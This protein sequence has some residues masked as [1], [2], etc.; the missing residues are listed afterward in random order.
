MSTMTVPHSRN[1]TKPVPSLRLVP[2]LGAK[3]DHLAELRELIRRAQAAEREESAEV[4]AGL[5]AAGLTRLAGDRAVA[6]VGE[7][8]SLTVDPELFLEA[9][10]PAGYAAVTVSVTAARRLMGADDL[11]AISET[12]TTP[13]LRL[14]AREEGR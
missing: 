3:V 12:T 2:S 10:G 13:V 8:I 1:G 9:V 11:A 7:R 4:L 14:E 6:V 5:E